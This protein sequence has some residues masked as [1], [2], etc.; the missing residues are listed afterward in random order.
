KVGGLFVAMKEEKIEDEVDGSANALKTL[1]GRIKEIK[2]IALPGTN[3]VRSLVIIE[4]IEK[5]PIKYPRRAGM[6]GKR[7]L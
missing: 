1:G 6:A 3:I 5:T 4:K 2:K 7:P